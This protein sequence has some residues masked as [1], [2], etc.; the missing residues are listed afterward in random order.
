MKVRLD[1]FLVGG[2]EVRLG[3]LQ[4]HILNHRF[5]RS[6]DVV[7]LVNRVDVRHVTRVQDIVDVF[8]ERL[9]FDL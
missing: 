4:A 3:R 6:I 5:H 2:E 1:A 8:Q 9:T 7:Q